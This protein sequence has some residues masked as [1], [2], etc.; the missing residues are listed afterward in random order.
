MCAIEKLRLDDRYERRP[1]HLIVRFL[2]CRDLDDD[3]FDETLARDRLRHQLLA[4]DRMFGP[5]KE[6]IY[7][8]YHLSSILIVSVDTSRR[9]VLDER[10]SVTTMSRL[11]EEVKARDNEIEREKVKV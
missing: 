3:E 8:R 5:E 4:F 9:T 7:L 11:K 1:S 10:I 6:V 2:H